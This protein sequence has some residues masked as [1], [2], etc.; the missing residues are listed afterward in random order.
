MD[1]SKND[2]IA[3]A[4]ALSQILWF[5]IQFFSRVN[6]FEIT[7]LE[8]ATLAYAVITFGTYIAWLGK[9]LGVEQPILITFTKDMQVGELEI[10]SEFV[11]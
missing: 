4:I 2:W 3:K 1:R 10:D 7:H 6:R 11:G 9:P 5:S 8:I